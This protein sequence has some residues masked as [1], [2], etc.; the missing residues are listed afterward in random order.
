MKSGFRDKSV[1]VFTE[2]EKMTKINRFTEKTAVFFNT[3]THFLLK[4]QVL[5]KLEKEL[6]IWKN[7]QRRRRRIKRR[8]KRGKLLPTNRWFKFKLIAKFLGKRR[9]I[10]KK[11]VARQEF[12]L[13]CIQSKLDLINQKMQVGIRLLI[14]NNMPLAI[15][16]KSKY[17]FSAF[18]KMRSHG[19]RGKLIFL[20]G[21]GEDV[22]GKL[23]KEAARKG[24]IYELP[25][26]LGH[27][28]GHNFTKRSD[29]VNAQSARE[30]VQ[31]AQ[32]SLIIPAETSHNDSVVDHHSSSYLFRDHWRYNDH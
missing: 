26:T 14:N 12:L 29:I 27:F 1:R 15:Q 8:I 7:I 16:I 5:E 30:R 20:S 2:E 25:T 23:V 24:I 13:S 32:Y 19:Y 18:L 3:D 31:E 11:R 4:F 21:I 22:V 10:N 28:D 9:P 17:G 6:S